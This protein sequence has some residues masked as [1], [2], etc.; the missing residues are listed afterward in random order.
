[1]FKEQ[2]FNKIQKD[3]KCKVLINYGEIREVTLRELLDFMNELEEG[4]H[5]QYNIPV[6]FKFENLTQK[7]P[8]TITSNQWQF[9]Q[10]FTYLYCVYRK[11]EMKLEK[12][13]YDILP[14]PDIHESR[15]VN[16]CVNLNKTK[17]DYKSMGKN[18]FY[19]MYPV[20]KKLFFCYADYIRYSKNRLVKMDEG[21]DLPGT[22][23]EMKSWLEK[24]NTVC[25]IK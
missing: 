20:L 11:I 6:L 15:F 14:D 17:K 10:F 4:K 24:L 1:M 22:I 9:R 19:E 21:K 13:G 7:V 5:S 18:N 3:V 2:N 16:I 8:E 25:T 23:E 12:A